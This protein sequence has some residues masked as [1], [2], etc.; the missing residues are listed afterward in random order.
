[1]KRYLKRLLVLT[2]S[3][4]A[5]LLL[6]SCSSDKPAKKPAPKEI[7]PSKQTNAKALKISNSLDE[8]DFS[9]RVQKY[10]YVRY[11]DVLNFKHPTKYTGVA[12]NLS[13]TVFQIE[14]LPN[15]NKSVYFIDGSGQKTKT[16]LVATKTNKHIRTDD[17][18]VFGTII[19]GPVKYNTRHHK[20][21]SAIAGYAKSDEVK[22]AGKM[23]D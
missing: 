20:Q 7:W 21:V 1:M 13:G 18:V 2:A 10:R 19:S 14:K 22:N 16:Y 11:S 6:T 9:L 8:L 17:Y 3:F 5:F 15:S 12:M 23:G 4:A